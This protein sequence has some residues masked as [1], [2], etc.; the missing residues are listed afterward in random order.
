MKRQIIVSMIVLSITFSACS[1][2]QAE[3]P[4][5]G[6]G[7][8]IYDE[9]FAM[10]RDTRQ[11]QFK[12]GCN[13]IKFTD[14]AQTIELTSVS[15]RSVSVPAAVS[16]LEQSYEY[17]LANQ[18]SL[19]NRY[20]DKNITVVIKGSGADTSRQISG[21]LLAVTS[22]DLILKSE[23]NNIEILNQE[24]IENIS[25]KELPDDLATK[26]TLIWLA[27]AKE[28]GDHLCQASY[29]TEAI[30]WDVD[31][32]AIL[33]PDDTQIDFTGWVTIDNKSGATYKDAVIKL[34]AGDV[35]RQ[36]KPVPASR[37][38]AA[39]A[40]MEAAADFEGKSFA[41][42]HLYT[43][44]RKTTIN[45]NQTKRIEFIS[46]AFGAVVKKLYI[47]DQSRQK[48]KVQINLELENTEE[49]NLGIALA[50][51]RVRLFKKDPADQSLEFI[52][53]DRID[54]TA[55]GEKLSLYIGNAFDIAAEH[56]LLEQE[57]DRRMKRE[58]HKIELR[59]RKDQAVE[60]FVDEKFP[61][62]VN[63]TIDEST[64][65]YSKRDAHT[66]RF[67]VKLEADSTASIQYTATQRW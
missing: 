18:A 30:G 32:S 36:T 22:R 27:E 11:V 42:Y 15:F 50:K 14:V 25:L 13:A 40:P 56:T 66:A 28:N 47:F 6:V 45:N 24:S 20:I 60:V 59:N 3:V 46:P 38:K 55:K 31:Y 51:G 52:G 48:D 10:V 37:A 54:H 61:P 21:Q 44:G 64:H 39:F 65:K 49:N 34:I 43:L 1:A 35:R 58:K 67:K 23:A 62:N 7:L 57:V 26:P 33:N 8:T 63:W 29:I 16:I 17:D 53:E 4:Q 9:N 12:K 5:P 41:E 2:G 19:L